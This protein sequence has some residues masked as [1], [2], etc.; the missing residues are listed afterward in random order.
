MGSCIYTIRMGH[1]RLDHLG[2]PEAVQALIRGDLPSTD[3]DPLYGGIIFNFWCEGYETVAQLVQ[4][5]SSTLK[6]CKCHGGSSVMEPDV[7]EARVRECDEFLEK[8]GK[9]P[10]PDC[11]YASAPCRSGPGNL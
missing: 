11:F 3:A 4:T 7:F 5:I 6:D 2:G 10:G 1:Q 9:P 8:Y